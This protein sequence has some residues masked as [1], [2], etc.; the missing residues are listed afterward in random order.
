MHPPINCTSIHTR[1][2]LIMQD[3]DRRIASWAGL[4]LNAGS[5]TELESSLTDLW[6][7]ERTRKYSLTKLPVVLN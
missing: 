2:L 1:L 7:T 5:R 3:M 4:A 6:W